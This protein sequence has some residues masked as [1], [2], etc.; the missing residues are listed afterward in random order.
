MES[1]HGMESQD[2]LRELLTPVIRK[3]RVRVLG[4]VRTAPHGHDNADPEMNS[5]SLT[6]IRNYNVFLQNWTPQ[7]IHINEKHKELH[8]FLQCWPPQSIKIN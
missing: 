4:R 2:N 6:N 7:N 3:G 1:H 5:K 8:C